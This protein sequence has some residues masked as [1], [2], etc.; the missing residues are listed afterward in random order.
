[1][2]SAACP[3]VDSSELFPIVSVASFRDSHRCERLTGRD[4]LHS[5]R[6]EEAVAAVLVDPHTVRRRLNPLIAL[7]FPCMTGVGACKL[8]G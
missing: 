5:R 7:G 1:M 4:A 3:V 8:L 6:R 2:G